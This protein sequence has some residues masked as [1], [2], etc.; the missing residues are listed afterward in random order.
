MREILCTEQPCI[1]CGMALEIVTVSRD[2][3]TGR[4]AT[5]RVRLDHDDDDCRQMIAL[6]PEIWPAW[7]K[8]KAL[9]G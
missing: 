6:Y 3:E 1:L 7:G 4:E 8:G 9:K 2:E 5:V